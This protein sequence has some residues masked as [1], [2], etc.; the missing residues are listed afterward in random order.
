M[1]LLRQ[2]SGRVAF[3]APSSFLHPLPTQKLRCDEA[4]PTT[5]GDHQRNFT[6][7]GKRMK[8]LVGRSS[9]PRQ[10]I[11]K[12]TTTGT[13]IQWWSWWC[14]FPG[15]FIVLIIATAML[16]SVT[17]SS[18]AAAA[19]PPPA[20]SFHSTR[21]SCHLPWHFSIPHLLPLLRI[22]SEAVSTPQ[23]SLLSPACRSLVVLVLLAVAETF[24]CYGSSSSSVGSGFAQFNECN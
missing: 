24:Y 19:P 18:A 12:E 4:A 15:L 6:G 8:W 22:C 20:L 16:L 7:V 21:S 14:H 9:W 17:S 13:L 1:L 10:W 2:K 23:R 11:G 5:R 3:P